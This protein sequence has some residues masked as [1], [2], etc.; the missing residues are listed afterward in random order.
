MQTT[1]NSK[2]VSDS[3]VISFTLWV[4]F[5]GSTEGMF[6]LIWLLY[7]CCLEQNCACNSL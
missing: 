2:Q 1:Q 4:L 3:T 6:D 7:I 5:S